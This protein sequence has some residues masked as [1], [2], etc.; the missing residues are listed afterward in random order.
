MRTFSYCIHFIDTDPVA[1]M[2]TLRILATSKAANE[3][4]FASIF[5]LFL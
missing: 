4:P 1:P 5:T 3:F 2:V